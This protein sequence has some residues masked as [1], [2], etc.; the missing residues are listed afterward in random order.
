M[1]DIKVGDIVVCINNNYYKHFTIN[2]KYIVDFVNNSTTLMTVLNDINTS[3]IINMIH[4]QFV[5]L[6]EYELMIRKNKLEK[7]IK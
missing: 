4:K 1:L 7:I 6:N 2:E 5:T 3:S